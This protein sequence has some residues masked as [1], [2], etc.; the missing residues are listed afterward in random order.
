MNPGEQKNT[1]NAFNGAPFSNDPKIPKTNFDDIYTA[2]L[3]AQEIAIENYRMH[4]AAVNEERE[5]RKKMVEFSPAKGEI[6]LAEQQHLQRAIEARA[7]ID[8]IGNALKHTAESEEK[9]TFGASLTSAG[10]EVDAK[11]AFDNS[12]YS[13]T[14]AA[15]R[16]ELFSAYAS[17]TPFFARALDKVKNGIL[18]PATEASKIDDKIYDAGYNFGL[19]LR[20]FSLSMKS[21]ASKIS[22]MPAKI[23]KHVIES[24]VSV[25]EAVTSRLKNF[26]SKATSVLS[27]SKDKAIEKIIEVNDVRAELHSKVDS[28][29]EAIMERCSEYIEA[30]D[31][32]INAIHK[33][34]VDGAN[35]R[36]ES[37]QRQAAGL[38]QVVLGVSSDLTESTRPIIRDVSSKLFGIGASIMDSIDGARTRVSAHYQD[39]VLKEVVA[40]EAKKAPKP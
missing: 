25:K 40:Q 8:L 38:K 26:Y 9:F 33:A 22:N 4:I 10:N 28:S 19:Q 6:T 39:G 20:V 34:A 31:H 15:E 37:V 3:K 12:A 27:H 14:K 16:V 23:K 21:F 30:S 7:A 2:L 32:K 11:T 18:K 1:S 35:Q 36:K 24:G 17:A 13:M 29:F 5:N